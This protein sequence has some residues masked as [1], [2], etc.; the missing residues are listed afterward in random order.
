MVSSA[1]F[2]KELFSKGYYQDIYNYLSTSEETVNLVGALDYLDFKHYVKKDASMLLLQMLVVNYFSTEHMLYNPQKEWRIPY[3]H[4]LSSFLQ[5][6]YSTC[7]EYPPDILNVNDNPFLKVKSLTLT[8]IGYKVLEL[9]NLFFTE[10]Y[11]DTKK[12]FMDYDVSDVWSTLFAEVDSPVMKKYYKIFIDIFQV[13]FREGCPKEAFECSD[14]FSP[15]SG[16]EGYEERQEC[17]AQIKM[18]SF[19]GNLLIFSYT[20]NNGWITPRVSK[21][22]LIESNSKAEVLRFV[23]NGKLI[24]RPSSKDIQYAI[25]KV[26]PDLTYRLSKLNNPEDLDVKSIKDELNKNYD[27]PDS[28][29]DALSWEEFADLVGTVWEVPEK[30]NKYRSQGNP[31]IYVTAEEAWFWQQVAIIRFFSKEFFR[32]TDFTFNSAIKIKSNAEVR[33]CIQEISKLV[34]DNPSILDKVKPYI[35]CLT[36]DNIYSKNVQKN[37]I[38]INKILNIIHSKV[39]E[40]NQAY[41]ETPRGEGSSWSHFFRIYSCSWEREIQ[42]TGVLKDFFNYDDCKNRLYAFFSSKNFVNFLRIALFFKYAIHTMDEN[43]PLEDPQRIRIISI[44]RE[45]W[46]NT[47]ILQKCLDE[48]MENKVNYKSPVPEGFKEAHAKYYSKEITMYEFSNMFHVS[49]NK[50]REWMKECNLPVRPRGVKKDKSFLDVWNKQ[51]SSIQKLSKEEFIT[52]VPAEPQVQVLPVEKVTFK[53]SLFGYEFSF[54]AKKKE[55]T[56]PVNLSDEFPD[57]VEY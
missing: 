54:K 28:I 25:E 42:E 13:L 41:Q 34:Q 14:L 9:S 31:D 35:G 20:C 5:D 8:P 47:R 45:T 57:E 15:Y 50:I 2:E 30:Y 4:R 6:A 1:I 43:L 18:K 23:Y 33:K 40:Y 24:Y 56:E 52:T 38:I 39:K 29:F 16:V 17:Y 37:L 22:G 27:F 46:W 11:R 21:K 51:K 32:T 7:S 3:E 53:F 12:I 36:K 55:P 49:D 26:L 10:L 44:I 48:I 19:I